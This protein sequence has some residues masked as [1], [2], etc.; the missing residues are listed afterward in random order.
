M[1]LFNRQGIVPQVLSAIIPTLNEADH[2]SATVRLLRERQG[3]EGV[4]VV[5]ADCGSSDGTVALASE[6]G[7]RVVTRATSRAVAMNRGAAAARGDILLFLHADS[8]LPRRFDLTIARAVDR[9]CVGGAFDFNWSSK[10][11]SR[12]VEREL[13]R[14]VRMTN[15]IRFRW[16]GNFYGDQGIFVRRDV[17]VR[18]GG[19]PE[20][21]LMEDIR[22]CQK[23]KRVGRLAV[24]QPP[25][26]TSPRRFLARG[27]VRQF[28]AD[29]RLLA[30]ES[31][32]LNPRRA[33]GSYNRLNRLG[34]L[35]S[36]G[37]PVRG[38]RVEALSEAIPINHSPEQVY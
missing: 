1:P 30:C 3:G 34:H 24:L 26:K 16:T 9:G 4:E 2:L 31:C 25:V 23:L 27:V 18:L 32:G 20:V 11:R 19:F 17:F 6:L 12:G 21:P 5:V 33:W 7:C 13:L 29:L 14:I 35:P 15:R 36:G 37:T 38:A 28:L 10:P 22:L 8:Q